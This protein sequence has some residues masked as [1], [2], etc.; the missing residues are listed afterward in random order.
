MTQNAKPTVL[1]VDDDATIRDSLAF[2]L[3]Q[4]FNVHVAED[5]QVALD[6]L[7]QLD[8]PPRLA[9]VDLGLPPDI[10][11]PTEG[12]NLIA[13][14]LAHNPSTKILV[15]S[16]QTDR[17]NSRHSLT[18]GASEVIAKPC[19]PSLLIARLE[20]QL[21]LQEAEAESQQNQVEKIIG[22]SPAVQALKQQI[23]QFAEGPF[24]VLIEGETGTGKELVAAELHNKSSRS[25][26]PYVV[27]N[28]AALPKD[29][30]E[31][32]LFGHVKGAFTGAQTDQAG[33]FEA[34]GDGT[35]FLDEIGEMP[36]ELQ[37]KLLRVLESGSFN[38]VGETK[39]RASHARIIAATNRNLRDTVQE[40]TF[41]DDLYHRLSILNL[42]VPALRE[43]SGDR[44]I[45][46]K[47]FKVVYADTVPIFQLDEE[48]EKAWSE[49]PFPGN[50]RELRNI[51][52]RLGT[53]YPGKKVNIDELTAEFEPGMEEEYSTLSTAEIMMADQ[54]RMEHGIFDLETRL[55]EMERNYIKMAMKLS[56]GNLSKTAQS[57]NL[58]RTT[59]YSRLQRLGIDY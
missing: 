56:E 7:N 41:R 6:I 40:G 58:N 29:L 10:H 53:R 23:Q 14:V 45:L 4:K 32:Q 5:R 16:G 59:L 30:I 50:I 39:Q 3:E 17:V 48:A 1:L 43:R 13:D 2:V 36:I 55:V 9:L 11:R 34:A 24:S 33:Y 20:H 27:V 19:D 51:V 37:A 49:Y 18:L 15:L 47:H 46:F 57:L 22:D 31:A 44:E 12:F 52:I 38:R 28:C 8:L 26:E 21:L 35:L 25:S 54:A 42:K